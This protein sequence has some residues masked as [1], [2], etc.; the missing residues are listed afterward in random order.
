MHSTYEQ[1]TIRD[2]SKIKQIKNRKGEPRGYL[3][4]VEELTWNPVGIRVHDLVVTSN[5]WGV[6]IH[7]DSGDPRKYNQKR[8]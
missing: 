1:L 4:I 7:L 8:L 6:Y 3:E 5:F 2:S